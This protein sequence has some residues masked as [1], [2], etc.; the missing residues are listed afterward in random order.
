VRDHFVVRVPR[1]VVTGVLLVAAAITCTEP[2][3]LLAVFV[4]DAQAK[5]TTMDE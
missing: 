3:R 5:L 4:A 1:S 2:A